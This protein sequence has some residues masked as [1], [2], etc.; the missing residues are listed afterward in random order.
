MD[1]LFRDADALLDAYAA[2][3]WA[4]TQL[5]PVDGW[6]PAL[7]GAVDLMLNTP[8]PVTLIWGA[9]LV[10]VY[11]AA[12]AELIGGKHP[13]A[14]G[15]RCVD[16]FPEAW[17]VIGPLLEGVLLGS[18]RVFMEDSYLPLHRNGFLEEC[19]FNY[20]YSP[21]HAPDGSVE[22]VIDICNEVTTEV[23][24]VR[25]LE[26]LTRLANA[27]ATAES[28]DEVV[29][30]A[31]EVLRADPADL[32]EVELWM[33]GTAPPDAALPQPPDVSTQIAETDQ[34]S[35]AWLRLPTHDR[36]AKQ[37]RLVARLS[38]QLRPDG[39]FLD[40]LG[41]ISVPIAQ[42]LD[43]VAARAGERSLSES[44]QRS[45]LTRPDTIGS[46]EVAVRYLPAS[47]A[48]QIGGDWY[49]SF[50]LP[51]GGLCVV[52]GDVAGHDQR[53]AAAMAQ[54]R[55]VT[56]G[57]AYAGAASPAQVLHGLDRVIDGLDVDVVATAVL[58]TFAPAEQGHAVRW[59]NAGHPPPVLLRADGEVLLLER[60]P[61]VLL[62]LTARPVRE[63]H[64]V[65]LEPGDALVLYSDGLVE[66][67]GV[68]L[69][70]SLGWLTDRLAGQQHLDP[71]SLCER[72][73]DG[74]TRVEDDIALL[75]VRRGA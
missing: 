58:A 59:S 8:N 13:A 55:N 34:G 7:R 45:L 53:A 44:L 26:L 63:E 24:A 28:D 46:L 71:E 47:E 67:R 15:R 40:F 74:I 17:D 18:G 20:A 54:L 75:V 66:R 51:D 27:L 62:G 70:D 35:V 25:R 68:D 36:V 31:L 12:Y 72:L 73:L 42:A 1:A 60:R 65:P 61:D 9:E 38:P 41:L 6:S 49:D 50:P 16:V 57:L 56:R 48:M 2:V 39:D 23:L 11:N 43:R 37:A 4:A 33:G 32:V 14:L 10:L 19:W 52:V 64:E 3:D 21:V 29:A 69:E 22:G 5:G 30:R